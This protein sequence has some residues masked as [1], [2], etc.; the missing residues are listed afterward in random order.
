M[1]DPIQSN[2]LL[3][4]A[5][6]LSDAKEVSNG[7]RTSLVSS[8]TFTGISQGTCHNLQAQSPTLA[9][10]LRASFQVKVGPKSDFTAA[11]FPWPPDSTAFKPLGRCLAYRLDHQ[12]Q[13]LPLSCGLRFNSRT[14]Y[15]NLNPVVLCF[16]VFRC[17]SVL[18]H[19][20]TR[21]AFNHADVQPLYILF[22]PNFIFKINSEALLQIS[23]HWPSNIVWLTSVN[24]AV[25][26]S[27][28]ISI[29]SCLLGAEA[30]EHN[31]FKKMDSKHREASSRCLTL[32][33]YSDSANA[34]FGPGL[35]C[36]VCLEAHIF[37]SEVEVQ[38]VAMSASAS[39][40]G[41][42]R[43][44]R[45]ERVERS[46]ES[47]SAVC[48][49]AAA[50]D[51]REAVASETGTRTRGKCR[52]LRAR[53]PGKERGTIGLGMARGARRAERA[54]AGTAQTRYTRRG[55]SMPAV[56]VFSFQPESDSLFLKQEGHHEELC[57]PVR[58][59]KCSRSPCTSPPTTFDTQEALPS[60]A[61]PHPL[62]TRIPAAVSSR[63]PSHLRIA[64][65]RRLSPA[66]PFHRHTA[67]GVVPC[68]LHVAHLFMQT[69]ST[70]LV[71]THG[72]GGGASSC[73]LIRHI[74]AACQLLDSLPARDPHNRRPSS[75]AS[76]LRHVTVSSALA[77]LPY[78]YLLSSFARATAGRAEGNGARRRAEEG[79]KGKT[80]DAPRLRR[81]WAAARWSSPEEGRK[82]G[83]KHDEHTIGREEEEVSSAVL[84]QSADS[85]LT[86]PTMPGTLDIG[87]V[88]GVAAMEEWKAK[89]IVRLSTPSLPP[90]RAIIHTAL[91][92]LQVLLRRRRYSTDPPGLPSVKAPCPTEPKMR[93]PDIHFIWLS[94]VVPVPVPPASPLSLLHSVS[95]LIPLAR[96]TSRPH[97]LLRS[98]SRAPPPSL[99]L[100]PSFCSVHPPFS[101][102]SSHSPSFFAYLDIF[103]A[104]RV[105]RTHP[106]ADSQAVGWGGHML[107]CDVGAGR[108]RAGAPRW[109][110]ARAVA[111]ADANSRSRAVGIGVNALAPRQTMRG[112][113]AGP[114][115]APGPSRP[116]SMSVGEARRMLRAGL[117]I[118]RCGFPP[119]RRV[120][121]L[122]ARGAHVDV[123]AGDAHRG[124]V[125]IRRWEEVSGIHERAGQG[126]S[127]LAR[128]MVSCRGGRRRCTPSACR[129]TGGPWGSFSFHGA[130]GDI[131]S[132]EGVRG[133][134][135]QRHQGPAFCVSRGGGR[136]SPAEEPAPG[137]ASE[138]GDGP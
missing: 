138:H 30:G 130:D 67:D 94:F 120:E 64:P 56:P 112:D 34:E 71:Q 38:S 12:V 13:R 76:G 29:F 10:E 69:H 46:A 53:Y 7:L 136:G 43:V 24:G 15:L 135:S 41:R 88:D 1:L 62:S 73:K 106:Q 113:D 75:S 66:R 11:H 134:E 65:R 102:P 39:G 21:L 80:E 25:L 14:F 22:S 72:K 58:H 6:K 97:L 107:G 4:E 51:A 103:Q 60:S 63:T 55:M 137:D 23:L 95:P 126:R 116:M 127:T 101:P 33:F 61:H 3:Q 124:L 48:R 96:F 37:C 129:V 110:S 105:R 114:R 20:L 9:V 68:R 47:E 119:R 92:H 57:P 44:G 31:P 104:T 89:W 74:S 27:L 77:I 90:L 70:F 32:Q 118:C 8:Q 52:V 132:G 86:G 100:L 35:R 19:R 87:I 109:C 16:N 83:G 45:D 36:V 84:R 28:L 26:V 133:M 117:S 111:A 125:R 79:K 123:G 121:G 54:D 131:L 85:L 82:D 18:L 2:K 91:T 108:R 59:L 93:M 49:V 78:H 50:H 115:T 5:W 81:E 128:A 42:A 17:I 40:A 98:L 99:P 122:H